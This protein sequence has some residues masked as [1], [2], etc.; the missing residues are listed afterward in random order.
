MNIIP[1]FAEQNQGAAVARK[2]KVRKNLNI[3]KI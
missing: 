1:L 2:L 3:T